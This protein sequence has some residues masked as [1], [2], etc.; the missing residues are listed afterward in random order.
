[1]SVL[2]HHSG[3][4]VEIK[5]ATILNASPQGRAGRALLSEDDKKAKAPEPVQVLPPPKAEKKEEAAAAAAGEEGK[6]EGEE[7]D[8]G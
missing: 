5:R 7:T 4:A 6:E 3:V 8:A 1:M 2:C